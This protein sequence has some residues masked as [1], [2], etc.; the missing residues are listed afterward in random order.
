M[1]SGDIEI[2]LRRSMIVSSRPI[3]TGTGAGE[4]IVD[5][6][7]NPCSRGGRSA[8]CEAMSRLQS[9]ITPCIVV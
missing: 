4:D 5:R 8:G 9:M 3:A 1:P 7:C 6:G 2:E